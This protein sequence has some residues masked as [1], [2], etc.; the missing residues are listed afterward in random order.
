M[1]PLVDLHVID[2]HGS[3]VDLHVYKASIND[4]DLLWQSVRLT[5]AK[6][7]SARIVP[8]HLQCSMLDA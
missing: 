5:L 2:L 4:Y 1:K 7:R 3:F 6:R 8:H